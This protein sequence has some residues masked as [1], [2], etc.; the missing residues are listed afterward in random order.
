MARLPRLV[1]PGLAHY[2]V[3][4]GHNGVR[5]ITD[6]ADRV[7]NLDGRALTTFPWQCWP[8]MVSFNSL[9][10]WD[11]KGA[12]GHGEVQDFFELPQLNALNSADATR[13]PSSA[14]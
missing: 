10:E 7:W 9:C 5:V 4:R 6:S 1:L 2:V 3:L 8:N 11:M 14:L 12:K 13:R